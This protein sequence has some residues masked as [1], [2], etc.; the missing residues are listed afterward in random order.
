MMCRRMMVTIRQDS[1]RRVRRKRRCYWSPL[2]LQL[3]TAFVARR[4]SVLAM[5]MAVTDGVE[6][7]ESPV[8]CFARPREP[9]L[10]RANLR[11]N[12]YTTD[13]RRKNEGIKPTTTAIT[14]ASLVTKRKQTKTSRRKHRPVPPVRCGSPQ[15]RRTDSSVLF[16]FCFCC[17]YCSFRLDEEA[18]LSKGEQRESI[19]LSTSSVIDSS[20]CRCFRCVSVCVLASLEHYVGELLL[21][22]SADVQP[23][24]K[25]LVEYELTSPALL[26]GR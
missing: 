14:T 5:S 21:L 26:G 11:T 18:F 23:L 15:K 8:R 20:I 13:D 2:S 22:L 6:Q 9:I 12:G 17:C 19:C 3:A 24:P 1:K 7:R 10:Q 16:F 25:A 4:T